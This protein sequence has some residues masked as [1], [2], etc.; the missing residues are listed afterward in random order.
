MDPREEA[1]N[2]AWVRG[3]YRDLFAESG[4]VPVPGEGCDGAFINH[5]LVDSGG[6]IFA[7]TPRLGILGISATA[8]FQ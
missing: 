5:P 7:G 2:L 6:M 1:T 8:C 4:G 3:F